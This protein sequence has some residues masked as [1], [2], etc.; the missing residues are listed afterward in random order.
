VPASGAW[1]SRLERW[2]EKEPRIRF[3]LLVG[4][5]ARTNEP[6]DPFSDIDLVLFV[7][8]P[9]AFVSDERWIA[10]LG[11]YWTSHLEGNAL[12]TGPERRVLFEDGQDVDFAVFPAEFVGALAN[13]DRAAAVLR[14]G[15]RILVDKEAVGLAAPGRAPSV[16]PPTLSEFTNLVNDYWF[17]LVWAAKKLRRGELRTALG[18]TNGYLGALLVRAV[19]WHALV[20][21]PRG[22]E[23]WHAERYFEKWADPRVIRELPETVARYDAPSVA[24]A[25]RANRA[26]FS[27]LTD[28]VRE[29]LSYPPAIRDRPGLS[30]YLDRI[31][32]EGAAASAPRPPAAAGPTPGDARNHDAR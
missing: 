21:G 11:A 10:G 26:L 28:E 20:R 25:L 9:D 19:R 5:Q 1:I 7:T 16:A 24:R 27:W 4:S 31:L 17:H 22:R 12:E 18:A 30:A 13:D 32:D 6:A 3:A 14:R 15:F 29:G 23:V 2:A 8:D